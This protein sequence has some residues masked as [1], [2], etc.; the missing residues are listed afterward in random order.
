M[1]PPKVMDSL[2]R[3][4]AR[5]WYPVA[6]PEDLTEAFG[7]E[8][9]NYLSYSKLLEKISSCHLHPQKLAKYMPRRLAESVFKHATS[10]EIFKDKSIASYY[11]Q[12]GCIE[13]VLSFDHNGT[14]R[15]VYLLH[16][17]VENEEGI[18]LPLHSTYV[19]SPPYRFAKRKVG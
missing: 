8:L 19:G 15:R 14:L 17:A 18:E 3:F 6:L 7:V 10:M 1:M 16:K 4:F 5:I 2:S 13:F 9:S 12:E 11:F